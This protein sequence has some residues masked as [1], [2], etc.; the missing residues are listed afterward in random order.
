MKFTSWKES[1]R[2][3]RQEWQGRVFMEMEGQGKKHYVSEFMGVLSQDISE[4]NLKLSFDF[5]EENG[6]WRLNSMPITEEDIR[7]I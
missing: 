2:Q 3:T 1:F 6:Q 7:Y 4:G 5:V